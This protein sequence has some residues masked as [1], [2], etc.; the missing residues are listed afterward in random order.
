MI[1]PVA[2]ESKF[3]DHHGNVLPDAY[4]LKDDST[5][6]DLARGV[7]TSLLENYILAIDARTGIRLKAQSTSNRVHEI[8]TL[9]LNAMQFK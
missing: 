4:L 2:D 8:I 3:S 1:Y 5:P 7:H 9:P 6:L